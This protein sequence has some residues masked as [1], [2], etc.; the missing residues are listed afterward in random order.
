MQ[1]Y[2]TLTVAEFHALEQ[3]AG[4]PFSRALDM[5]KVKHTPVEGLE[6]EPAS[7]DTNQT[8]VSFVLEYRAGDGWVG[9]SSPVRYGSSEFQT[10]ADVCRMRGDKMADQLV[11][12][13]ASSFDGCAA[14]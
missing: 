5:H 12:W 3:K 7:I 2:V 4:I 8:P 10:E 13:L 1:I 11:N 6:S 14:L 9:Y